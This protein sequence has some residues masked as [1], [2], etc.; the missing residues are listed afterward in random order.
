MVKL[1]FLVCNH[2]RWA[3]KKASA[4]QTVVDNKSAK[5]IYKTALPVGGGPGLCIHNAGTDVCLVTNLT[6]GKQEA[7]RLVWSNATVTEG[8]SN[9]SDAHLWQH[10]RYSSLG[11]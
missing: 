10:T 2:Q 11:V 5:C 4:V 6:A 3:R 1:P 7:K 9:Y 8:I